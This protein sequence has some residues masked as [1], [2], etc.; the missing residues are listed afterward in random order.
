MLQQ[1]SGEGAA[2]EARDLVKTFGDKLAVDGV[3]LTVGECF[4][5]GRAHV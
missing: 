4:Q 5:I 2:V 3:S 1:V